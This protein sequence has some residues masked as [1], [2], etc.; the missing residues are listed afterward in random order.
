MNQENLIKFNC[1]DEL[2]IACAIFAKFVTNSE[3]EE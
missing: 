3:E 2:V 1:S